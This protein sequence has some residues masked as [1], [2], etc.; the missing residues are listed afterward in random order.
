MTDATA[1]D[2]LA[3]KLDTAVA[4]CADIDHSPVDGGGRCGV[5]CLLNNANRLVTSGIPRRF[6]HHGTLSAL[7]HIEVPLSPHD[8]HERHY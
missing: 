1:K 4:A 3:G 7:R 8:R 5:S 2:L 6:A